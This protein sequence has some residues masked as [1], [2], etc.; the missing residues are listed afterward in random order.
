MCALQICVKTATAEYV[1]VRPSSTYKKLFSNLTEKADLSSEVK[2]PQFKR[3]L[4]M[5]AAKG[6]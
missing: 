1:A 5:A 2:L 3:T 4:Q 6:M